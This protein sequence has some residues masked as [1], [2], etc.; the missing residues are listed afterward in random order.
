[1]CN[2]YLGGEVAENKEKTPKENKSTNK[3]SN[4]NI[5]HF[6]LYFAPIIVIV[7][8][9]VVIAFYLP[10]IFASSN[11]SPAASSAGT[12]GATSNISQAD[13]EKSAQATK[14]IDSINTR[15]NRIN[16]MAQKIR[17]PITT[18][19][20]I[21]DASKDA[22]VER[23]MAEKSLADLSLYSDVNL[24]QAE[25][26]KLG[27]AL[28]A[29]NEKFRSYDPNSPYQ[30]ALTAINYDEAQKNAQAAKDKVDIQSQ[31]E[32][33]NSGRPTSGKEILNCNAC[34][35]TADNAEKETNVIIKAWNNLKDT[36]APLTNPVCVLICKMSEGYIQLLLWI[37]DTLFKNM[38]V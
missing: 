21:K 7:I 17:V 23:D 8:S 34:S 9:V 32:Q 16:D 5:R 38:T 25:K 2:L 14:I 12:I 1:M 18:N 20:N 36:F 33:N 19:Q 28:N 27:D 30:V 29:L 6:L 31:N 15:I 22:T 4:F 24:W 37:V 35:N 3:K 10:N 11:T 26:N 13:I